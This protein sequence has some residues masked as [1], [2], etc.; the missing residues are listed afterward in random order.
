MSCTRPREVRDRTRES[1][2]DPGAD[3]VEKREVYPVS[4]TGAA[5]ARLRS[6][7]AFD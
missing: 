3:Q 2:G 5:G 7:V 6:G 4:W 1:A